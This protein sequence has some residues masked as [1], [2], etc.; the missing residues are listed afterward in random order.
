MV[1]YRWYKGTTDY[2]ADV[3]VFSGRHMRWISPGIFARSIDTIVTGV[4]PVACDFWSIMVDKCIEEISR[5]MAYDTI[6]IRIAMNGCICRASGACQHIVCASIMAG[7]TVI[8]DA[9]V[10]KNRWEECSDRMTD[11]TILGRR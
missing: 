8:A 5:I 4:T 9:R 7:G 3:T 6:S 1:K 11:V 10:S 2:M